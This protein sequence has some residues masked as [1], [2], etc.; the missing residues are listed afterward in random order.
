MD[1]KDKFLE[2]IS[3]NISYC[4]SLNEKE[5][6]NLRELYDKVEKLLDIESNTLNMTQNNN[7]SG[8][9][10]SNSFEKASERRMLAQQELKAYINNLNNIYG[11]NVETVNQIRK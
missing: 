6:K 5:L 3:S 4:D 7:T 11:V 1:N 10:Y 2:W 9:D 8:I